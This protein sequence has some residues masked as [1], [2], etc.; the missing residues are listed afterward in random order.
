MVKG[1]PAPGVTVSIDYYTAVTDRKG[2]VIFE[3]SAGRY[4]LQISRA[5]GAS[6]VTT[7]IAVNRD[8]TDFQVDLSEIEQTLTVEPSQPQ[9]LALGA[10][11]GFSVL[12]RFWEK[13]AV[14]AEEALGNVRAVLD[15]SGNFA[16]LAGPREL[17]TR[18]EIERFL[19][20]ARARG[21]SSSF[22]LPA[23]SVAAILSDG[24][25]LALPVVEDR[26]LSLLRDDDTEVWR[27]ARVA[28]GALGQRA[29]K[30]LL[31]VLTG[32]DY[33]TDLGVLVALSRIDGWRAEAG[34]LRRLW[35]AASSYKDRV[36]NN[37]LHDALRAVDTDVKLALLD[38]PP[39]RAGVVAFQQANGLVLDGIVGVSTMRALNDRVIATLAKDAGRQWAG[40]KIGVYAIDIDPALFERVKEMIRENGA[41]FR[42]GFIVAERPSWLAP[43]STVFYYS[44]ESESDARKL[45]GTLK[46]ELGMAIA[47][48][49]DAGLG[50]SKGEERG[51]YFVHLIGE[52]T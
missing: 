15:R 38:L 22:T 51:T 24:A 2:R 32:R 44:S 25:D 18:V 13:N 49:R 16:V 43:R 37:A 29:V 14:K 46:Q 17:Q 35:E 4:E 36:I 41:E 28:L 45:A 6:P 20:R 34:V 10:F 3:L 11:A 8:H 7:N 27:G 48:E 21:F 40:F 30:G 42:G 47:I 9:S 12:A 26:L 52:R 5:K 19:G 39:G 50:V 1:N 31:A 33:R 23:E